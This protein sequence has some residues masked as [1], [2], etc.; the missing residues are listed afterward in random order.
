MQLS[1]ER[2]DA[3]AEDGSRRVELVLRGRIDAETSVD[4]EAAVDDHLRGGETTI[5]LDCTEVGFLSSAGIRALFN[6]GR[7]AK[8]AGGTCLV[9]GA[10]DP[11]RRVL[12]LARLAPLLMEGVA[13]VV[14]AG[15]AAR[16]ERE[17]RRG[18]LVLRGAADAVVAPVVARRHGTAEWTHGRGGIDESAVEIPRQGFGVGIGCLADEGSAAACGG[19]FVAA[20]GSVFV[21]PPRPFGAPDSLVGSGDLRPAVRLVSGLVWQG[22]PRGHADFEAAGDAA[23]VPLPELAAALLDLLETDAAAIVAVAEVHGL[24]GAELIRPVAEA[25]GDDVPAAG[26]AEVAARWLSY[27]RE[28][29][30]AGRTALVVGVAARRAAGDLADF[31]RPLG[32]ADS[33]LSGHFHAVVFPHRPSRRGQT[34][35]RPLVDDLGGSAPLAV[36]HLLADPEPVLGS[37]VSDF[38]RGVCWFAPLDLR[39]APA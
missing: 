2:R 16:E 21:R 26:K 33:A 25:S 17:V 5:R 27:S 38:I 7:A 19:E 3:V 34:D 11:V 4:L 1:I 14:A 9:S 15:P 6:V 32:G 31:V 12:T 23:A 35:P 29:A 18:D 37:G 20:C 28:P 39:G 30:H 13:A 36:M 22:A 24:V 8:G 10:S